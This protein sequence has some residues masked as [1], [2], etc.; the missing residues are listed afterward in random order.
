MLRTCIRLASLTLLV[1]L[2]ACAEPNW[3]PGPGKPGYAL[4]V[5][6]GHCRLVAR[7][8]ASSVGFGARGS[9]KFVAAAAAGALLVGV[10][11]GAIENETNYRN[12]MMAQNWLIGDPRPPAPDGPRANQQMSVAISAP[13]ASSGSVM[14]APAFSAPNERR[15]LLVKGADVTE[16]S[17]QALH[18]KSTQGVV[19]LDVV[20][21][22][23][24]S[25]AGLQVGDTI[26]AFDGAQVS[27]M[28]DLQRELG[29]VAAGA[30]VTA[31]VW[32]DS[33]RIPVRL[34]F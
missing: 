22:G 25:R 13:T 31:D 32:R 28:E 4:G 19:L 18:L 2:T 24:G 27:G 17:E 15:E 30:S 23:A 8:L 3:V 7:G 5:D 9:P 12:C 26:L 29:R 34:Q 21:G 20:Y 33:R 14:A 11:G 1:W 6:Q 16:F 10:I